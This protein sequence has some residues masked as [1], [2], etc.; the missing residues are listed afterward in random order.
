MI[1]ESADATLAGLC[2][3]IR[4]RNQRAPMPF[5][6][7]MTLSSEKPELV[8]RDVF[9]MFYD[10]I[11][12]YVGEGVDEYPDDPES[13]NYVY[14]DCS[15]L[16]V[17][18]VDHP[19]FADRL[20]A[21]RL[22]HHI[23]SFKRGFQQ[24]RIYIFEGPHG[25]G[26]STFLNNV[27]MK[28]EHYTRTEEGASYETL[29]RLD[30]KELGA[31]MDHETYAF[32][33]QVRSLVHDSTRIPNGVSRDHRLSVPKKEYLEVPCP[34]HDSPLLLIPKAHRRELLD[35]LIID[36]EFKEG[37]FTEKA[38]EWVFRDNP[39]TICMSLYET[40]LDLLDSPAK[41]FDMIYAR[42]YKFNRRLGEGISVFNPGDKV[43]RSNV[44]TNELLQ[45][46]LNG[47]LKDSNRVRYIFSRYA[48]TNNGIY[49]LMDV[50]DNNKE[51]FTNLHGIISEGVHKV[52]DI[53][54][55][56]NSLFLALM[57][58]EDRENIADTQS[59]S[60]R[61]IYIKIAYVLDYNT[62]VRIYRNVFGD[63]IEASFLPRV[64]QNF[65]KV[66]ISSRLKIHSEGLAEWIGDPAK[67][68]PYCDQNLQLLKMDIFA[69]LIPSWLTEEDRKGFTAKR[70]KA[71]IAESE[72]EGDKGFS[73]RDSIKIFNEFYSTYAKKDK[74]INMAM[75]CNFF[76]KSRGDQAGC[77]PDGFLDSLV[78]F[79]NYTVL[80]EVKES[81]YFYNE[82][83][84]SKDIQNY[85]FAINFEPG[86]VMRCF[87]TGEELSITEDFL[88]GIERRFLGSNPDDAQRRSFRKDIQNHYASKTL[89]QEMLLEGRGICET[90]VYR[91]LYG[92]YVHNLKEK[93]MDPF[94][95]N[96]NFRT[97]IKDYATDSFKTYDKRV[98][99]EVNF[100]MQ[101][102]KKKHGYTRQGAKEVCIYVI[103]NDL[104]KTYSA[105]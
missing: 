60:D 40:L 37:L 58:P 75:V 96:D 42:R 63:R 2:E 81:L 18:E 77:V 9:Q 101:N 73:G 51:R 80:Q 79:Y 36:S 99:D 76:R 52:E 68:N 84:I 82:E 104:A 5:R 65:A 39:C 31:L 48:K 91:L 14:Y 59:F 32:L 86:I 78:R 12:R 3:S 53:E 4:E 41:V 67:Y 94:L 66:I 49:A 46:Q 92:R 56:V 47:L 98:R 26:K 93:V 33:S 95:K 30:Q 57:N 24:N 29:W 105:A 89:T 71:I 100:L 69:G 64:L 70:R 102:L 74:L 45:N 17:E 28:F 8:F 50:K 103:D 83:R 21:N 11:Y 88:D 20:F 7:F 44:I 87:F 43:A 62:E 90:E 34:S 15:N 61:I 16:L 38:Y 6:K 13:I 54:E 27:L 85:L 35:K 55:D 10:M 1:M 23:A 22:I 19:F 97:A 72:S 25:C